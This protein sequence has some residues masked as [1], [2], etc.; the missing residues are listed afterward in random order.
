MGFPVVLPPEIHG[1]HNR[2]RGF[3]YIAENE[4][5]GVRGDAGFI[6]QIERPPDLLDLDSLAH[7]LQ[8]RVVRALQ[9]VAHQ[10]ASGFLHPPQQIFVDVGNAHAA[11]PVDFVF[12]NSVAKLQYPLLG[13]RKEFAGQPDIFQMVVLHLEFN[14]LEDII[15]GTVPIFLAGRVEAKCT[16]ERAGTVGQQHA[17]PAEEFHPLSVVEPIEI[18][19]GDAVPDRRFPSDAPSGPTRCRRPGR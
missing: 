4:I 10:D 19:K 17:R 14:F 7:A 8:D 18:G 6:G 12:R 2:F 15:Q 5:G 3:V 13:R 16:A 11:T 9:S 1:V